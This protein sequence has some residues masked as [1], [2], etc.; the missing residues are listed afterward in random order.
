MMQSELLLGESKNILV[1]FEILEY[2]SG[3]ASK[4]LWYRN[5]A[6]G[7]V[8]QKLVFAGSEEGKLLALRQSFSEVSF[9]RNDSCTCFIWYRILKVW[10]AAFSGELGTVFSVGGFCCMYSVGI[11]A[12]L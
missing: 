11:Y 6:N 10:L 3:L 9:S 1:V 7:S 2:A 5:T 8:K 4:S 12:H